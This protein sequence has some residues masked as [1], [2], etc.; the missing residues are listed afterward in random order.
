M[1]HAQLTQGAQVLSPSA[2]DRRLVA[3]AFADVAGY[4][5]LM[6]LNDV[7]TVR[8]WKA[9]RTEVIEPLM[10]SPR[11]RISDLAGDGALAE[12]TSAVNAVRWACDVQRA[13][14]RT[15]AT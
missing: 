7:D 13:Q 12:F 2:I 6:A 9:L 10:T 1:K 14:Q 5:R 3:V 8:R 15:V 11:G 4:S